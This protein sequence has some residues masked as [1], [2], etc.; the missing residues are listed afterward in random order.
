MDETV[1]AVDSERSIGQD[2]DT[3]RIVGFC[4]GACEGQNVVLFRGKWSCGCTGIGG[5]TRWRSSWTAWEA[6]RGREAQ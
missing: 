2:R 4:S 6:N 3:A 1:R 5:V